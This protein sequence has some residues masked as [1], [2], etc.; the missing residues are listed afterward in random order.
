MKSLKL[1]RGKGMIMHLHEL[2]E[3]RVAGNIVLRIIMTSRILGISKQHFRKHG[4][5]YCCTEERQHFHLKK[6]QKH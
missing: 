4:H 6:M 3:M 5:S 1:P 2:N